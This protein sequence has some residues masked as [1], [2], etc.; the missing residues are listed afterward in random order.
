M[1]GSVTERLCPPHI[2]NVFS[3]WRGQEGE[4]AASESGLERVWNCNNCLATPLTPLRIALH[5]RIFLLLSNHVPGT[6]QICRE[7]DDNPI[8]YNPWKRVNALPSPGTVRSLLSLQK[9]VH[10]TPLH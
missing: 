8:A 7:A 4:I 3:T 1:V 6:L 5:A 10:E 2:A 9:I